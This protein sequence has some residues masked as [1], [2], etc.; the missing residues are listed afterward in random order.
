MTSFSYVM[1][2]G[3]YGEPIADLVLGYIWNH[4]AGVNSVA[5]IEVQQNTEVIKENI[6]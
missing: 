2:L 4:W 1:S 6:A 5:R 3:R